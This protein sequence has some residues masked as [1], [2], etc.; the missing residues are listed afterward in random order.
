MSTLMLSLK[1]PAGDNDAGLGSGNFDLGLFLPS[2]WRLEPWSLHLMPGFIVVGD[3]ETSGPDITARNV[4]S[5]FA[6][7]A[8]DY[9]ESWTWLLQVNAY[10]SPLEFTD[11][12]PL[13]DGAVDLAIGL[14]HRVARNWLLA[15]SL[16]E[17]LT[18]TAPD[19]TVRIALRWM[20]TAAVKPVSD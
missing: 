14:H 12:E 17:D 9:D 16:S 1:L 11:I 2:R 8:Y 15:F 7:A 4:Y 13:D 3:P 5:L 6:G 20:H 18:R 10:S 19:F